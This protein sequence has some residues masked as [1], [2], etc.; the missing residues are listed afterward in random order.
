MSLNAQYV[1]STLSLPGTWEVC[2][3]GSQSLRADNNMRKEDKTLSNAKYLM[4]EL[5][6]I[7]SP[8]LSP[9]PPSLCC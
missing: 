9:L 2:F 3:L 6:P 4:T 7:L 5:K 8:H 1:L